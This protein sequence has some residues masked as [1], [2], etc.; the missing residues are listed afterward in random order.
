LWFDA[1]IS[2]KSYEISSQAMLLLGDKGKALRPIHDVD[3]IR[4]FLTG[5]G[6]AAIL[7]FPWLPFYLGIVFLFHPLLGV[8]AL[9]GIVV[10][11]CL[12]GLNE[13]AARQPIASSAKENA[14]RSVAVETSRSNAEVIWA[15]GMMPKLR[16]NWVRTNNE[17]LNKQCGAAD[18]ATLYGTAIKTFRFIL[19]SMILAT[20]A[21]LAINQEVSP[22]VM[23]A[24][25]IMSSRALSP[26]E[27]AV[28]HWRGFV[29]ARSS[30]E[31]LKEIISMKSEKEI[32]PLP[33]PNKSLHL[34]QFCCAQAGAKQPFVNNVSFELEAGTALGIIGP[35]GS[36][37]TTL[38]RGIL[39]VVPS[40]RGSVRFDGAEI[41]QWSE[42]DVGKFIGYLPQDIQ[43]FD[44][45][46]GDNISRFELS[47]HS[48]SVI[49]AAKMAGV[50]DLI[51]SFSDGYNTQISDGGLSISGGQRQRIALARALYKK[52][53]LLV[54]DEPNS[55]LDAE[56]ERAL[57]GAISAMRSIGSIVIVI[58]HRPSAISAVDVL[59]CMQEGKPAAIGP[60]QEVMKQVLTP[61]ASQGAG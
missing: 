13:Y 37:K 24:A 12:I 29:A 9:G 11:A 8:V 55:N 31:R 21:W 22:G 6:P 53:F 54:L 58:A 32:L 26:I 46:I 51:V 56:G 3:C 33:L 44:G 7:D 2:E 14:Q 34:N 5:S 57:V 35:S 15:M 10:I 39:G 43:L 30:L 52:P 48:N 59:L 61:V 60:K 18:H 23:I 41:G 17:Y 1:R 25:S 45:T 4:Q 40:L 38:A 28:S 47:S 49:E 42:E 16:Q 20:G 50:H 19:Q 36:G 27:Q